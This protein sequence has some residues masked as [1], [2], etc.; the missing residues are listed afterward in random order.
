MAAE[1]EVDKEMNSRVTN[2]KSYRARYNLK[3]A[4]FERTTVD[5]KPLKASN[6]PIIFVIGGPGCGKGTQCERIVK[7]YG[8]TH[9]STG[10]L[11]REE[12]ESGSKRGQKMSAI[13]KKGELVPL[14]V[15]LD[16]L[17]EAMMKNLSKTKGYLID[18]FPRE[19]AQGVEFEKQIKPCTMV[20]FFDVSDKTMLERCLK[21]GQTSG[22]V[23]DNEDTIRK[24]LAT[25]H[26]V[27]K[28]VV[29]FYKNK[30]KIVSEGPPDPLFVEVVT[31]I[32][33]TI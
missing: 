6:V 2:F 13:M 10:D 20:L 1:A 9:L 28:P 4:R 32:D 31:C 14:D 3:Q 11:L 16:L 30:V 25:F 27:S 19:I 23:D 12:V 24:R 26:G 8:F 22:R 33:A 18:G 5:I 29:D 7:R 21:R 15:V 17:K